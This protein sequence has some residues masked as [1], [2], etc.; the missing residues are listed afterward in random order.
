MSV[1]PAIPID[2]ATGVTR[3]IKAGCVE[4][5]QGKI[6]KFACV[7]NVEMSD[8]RKERVDCSVIVTLANKTSRFVIDDKDD[9][10]YTGVTLVVTT[11]LRERLVAEATFSRR[12]CIKAFLR[13]VSVT[14]ESHPVESREVN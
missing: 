12:A 1:C 9:D 14:A 5:P 13:A 3:A 10:A 11:V 4:A 8:T 2:V 7:G 6:S